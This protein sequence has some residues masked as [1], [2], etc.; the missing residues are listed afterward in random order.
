MIVFDTEDTADTEVGIGIL[1]RVL[2]L[3]EEDI[4]T[5]GLLILWS[6]P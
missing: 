6:L 4:D 2:I 1:R 3:I 5:E